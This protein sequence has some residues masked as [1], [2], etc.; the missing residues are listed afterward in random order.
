MAWF[1]P[2]CQKVIAPLF[3]QMKEMAGFLFLQ[4]MGRWRLVQY[5]VN[6]LEKRRRDWSQSKRQTV[7]NLAARYMHSNFFTTFSHEAKKT[8]APDDSGT[9]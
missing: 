2:L 9:P 7:S 3:Y 1:S 5:D 4:T 8:G 6:K